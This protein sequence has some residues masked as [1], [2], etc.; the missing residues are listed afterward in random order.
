M[1]VYVIDTSAL[2]NMFRWYPP[3]RQFFRP[4][5]DN[6]EKLILS[7]ELIAPYEV[8]REIQHKSDELAHWSRQHKIMF[9]HPDQ[10]Q[11]LILQNVKKAYDQEYWKREA[12]KTGAWAD[13]WVVTLAIKIKNNPLFNS[14]VKVVTD[15]NKIKPNRIPT[16]AA[17]FGIDSLNVLEFLW[18]IGIR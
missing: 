4:I 2:I 18:E 5:W 3:N 16:I 9:I 7:R 13:P 10:D 12:N 17:Q 14:E 1:N 6:V 11:V 8:Y 15:E